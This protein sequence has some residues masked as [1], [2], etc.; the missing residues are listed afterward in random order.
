MAACQIY[1]FHWRF[2]LCD[3]VWGGCAKYKP[4]W[5]RQPCTLK[6]TNQPLTPCKV[7]PLT[8]TVPNA[9][10]VLDIPKKK[11]NKKNSPTLLRI[12]CAQLKCNYAA[13]VRCATCSKTFCFQHT[14]PAG[15]SGKKLNL[16]DTCVI[17]Y[18]NKLIRGKRIMI[19][20][21]SIAASCVVI[22]VLATALAV[23]L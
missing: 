9:D 4:C 23:A 7:Q 6:M 1:F 20:A 16:C 2:F 14:V 22:I 10:V 3:L 21:L 12:K 11:N 15:S 17:D 13:N 18:N 5:N 19:I 8:T